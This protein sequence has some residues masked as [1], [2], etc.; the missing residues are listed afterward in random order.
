MA[1]VD[2]ISKASLR[3][4]TFKFLEFMAGLA[5]IIVSYYQDWID[6]KWAVLF[7]AVEVLYFVV[8]DIK[9]I[10]LTI[11]TAMALDGQMDKLERMLNR[12]L[13]EKDDS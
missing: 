5:L 3:E 6:L 2:K 12:E 8:N 10:L 1:E 13:P 4:K 7:F 9:D 11:L